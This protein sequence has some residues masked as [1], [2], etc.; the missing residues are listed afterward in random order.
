[1]SSR[2]SLSSSRNQTA[3][4]LISLHGG[5]FCNM[6]TKAV[7]LHLESVVKPDYFGYLWLYA[8]DMFEF[9]RNFVRVLFE[10]TLYPHY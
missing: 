4:R 10:I 6:P 5:F 9:C 3:R 7:I 8:Q 2:H 1:M